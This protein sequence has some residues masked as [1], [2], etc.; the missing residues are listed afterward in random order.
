MSK[1]VESVGGIGDYEEKGNKI[2]K[3][4]AREVAIDK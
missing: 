3:K 2:I 4:I 1:G